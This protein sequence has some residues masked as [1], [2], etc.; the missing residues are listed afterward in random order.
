[1]M[2]N[3]SKN[4]SS[5]I[6]DNPAEGQAGSTLSYTMQ[7]YWNNIQQ[8]KYFDEDLQL[9]LFQASS[10]IP[11]HWFWHLYQG[12]F[13]LD[14]AKEYEDMIVEIDE[15]SRYK[16]DLFFLFAPDYVPNRKT[17]SDFDHKIIG[18]GFLLP[19]SEL[20]RLRNDE[21]EPWIEHL[22]LL[23]EQLS[24][25][26]LFKSIKTTA[27][28][29]KGNTAIPLMLIGVW[30]YFIHYVEIQ[31]SIKGRGQVIFRL[32]RLD[33]KP[34]FEQL[35]I[36]L[37]TAAREYH[38]PASKKQNFAALL[39]KC[40]EQVQ[41][42]WEKYEASLNLHFKHAF[43]NNRESRAEIR[44]EFVVKKIPFYEKGQIREAC[45]A[46]YT[47]G[48]NAF[49]F[50]IL[51]EKGLVKIE[52]SL[53]QQM[54][55]VLGNKSIVDRIKE[56][57]K[58]KEKGPLPLLAAPS[59]ALY[60][61]RSERWYLYNP[62]ERKATLETSFAQFS[63]DTYQKITEE[64]GDLLLICLHRLANQVMA[65]FIRWEDSPYG[66]SSP[67]FNTLDP[68][69]VEPLVA[70][71]LT[72]RRMEKEESW[73]LEEQLEML[74]EWTTLSS[75][76]NYLVRVNGFQ[77]RPFQLQWEK[78]TQKQLAVLESR[79][80]YRIR[81]MRELGI[82]ERNEQPNSRM[83]IWLD[84]ML[85]IEK[86]ITPYISF[87]KKAFQSALPIRRSV[88]F[89]PYRHSHDGIEFDPD[90]VQDQEKWLSGNVMKTLRMRVDTADAEQINAFA[91]DASGSMTH[92][93]MRNLYKILY[94]MVLG[95]EDR[96]TFDAFHFFGTFFN[97][98]A[99]FTDYYTNRSL[100][101][102]ILRKIS[103]IRRNKVEYG[104]SGGTNLSEAIEECYNRVQDFAD[105]K[106]AANPETTYLTSIFVLTDGEPTLGIYDPP[107]L[108]RFIDMLRYEGNIAIKGI[109]MKTEEHISFME[110]VFGEGEYVETDSL[111]AAINQL[112]YIMS[113]TYKEQRKRMKQEKK[114]K[115]YGQEH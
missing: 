37:F 46:L 93:R 36:L 5:E 11:R 44:K 56:N 99:N 64:A 31:R 115:K 114:A 14:F 89:D 18:K 42:F 3:K 76:E 59:S 101:F 23:Q 102:L 82:L 29:Y 16:R 13:R 39:L 107:A 81:R 69:V 85:Q 7:S 33:Q 20:L 53:G 15:L 61:E 41:D 97:E 30:E 50:Q 10:E 87:V 1:M 78:A 67:Q 54:T 108:S 32:D 25:E 83:E 60:T 55:K 51:L 105:K 109:Y 90:T 92:D 17:W 74:Q 106:R 84:E 66:F 95:L 4:E 63:T 96:S 48:I 103:Y 21:I 57:N 75:L 47:E 113:L 58:K 9:M 91:L 110:D 80:N 86:E 24:F 26:K 62:A 52:K 65:P 12:S 28:S 2:K 88:E 73:R 19:E 49:I 38:L 35:I 72:V 22:Q 70:S 104:G 98:T 6:K 79:T 34:S 77:H 8:R 45:F 94:L 40:S 112:V 111:V 43:F 71:F 27:L 100:L 68:W